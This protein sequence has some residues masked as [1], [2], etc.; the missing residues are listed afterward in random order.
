M[1]LSKSNRERIVEELRAAA[2]FMQKVSDP[3]QKAYYYSAAYGVLERGFRTQFHPTLQFAFM[4][5]Q[6][7]YT[8]LNARAGQ[9]AAGDRLVPFV[10]G[11]WEGVEESLIELA[12]RIEHERDCF[13][14]LERISFFTFLTTGAGFY[15]YQRGDLKQ[16]R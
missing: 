11:V 5:L 3:R 7:S 10:E 14:V 16:Y 6:S 12:K 2:S 1:E 15:M 4:V 9:I 13:D 8:Q